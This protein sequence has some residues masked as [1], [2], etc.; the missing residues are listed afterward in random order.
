ME[1]LTWLACDIRRENRSGH[2]DAVLVRVDGAERKVLGRRS[3]FREYIEESRL[4]D[5]ES[6][7]SREIFV[8]VHK[9]IR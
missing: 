3:G 5:L 9:W 7:E 4:A 2:G 1:A 6:S 8:K